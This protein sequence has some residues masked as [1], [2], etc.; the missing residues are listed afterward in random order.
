M[1]KLLLSTIAVIF[2]FYI[3]AQDK[4]ITYIGEIFSFSFEKDS[5]N[6]SIPTYC[7][8][9]G[10]LHI[11]VFKDKK[12][13]SFMQ[14]TILSHSDS[15]R[16]NS[17]CHQSFILNDRNHTSTKSVRI[18]YNNKIDKVFFEKFKPDV[19]RVI[20]PDKE[21][22]YSQEEKEWREIFYFKFDSLP[23][24]EAPVY[25]YS[26]SV[27]IIH[28]FS[29]KNVNVKD[30]KREYNV[31]FTEEMHYN[32]CFDDYRFLIPG[33]VIYIEYKNKPYL[34]FLRIEDLDYKKSPVEKVI[35]KSV[36]RKW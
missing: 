4:H 2:S 12:S 11:L 13:I 23:Q 27:K 20:A 21:P 26:D 36:L 17:S 9:E 34:E 22:V 3:F 31:W 35:I 25:Q 15:I 7:T 24:W 10:Y 1:N 19:W 16:E 18:F 28:G 33:T 5:L 8:E 14:D 32:W 30:G 6:R 29:C